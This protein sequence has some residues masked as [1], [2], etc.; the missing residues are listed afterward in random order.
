MT[1]QGGSAKAQRRA[2][3]KELARAKREQER[4][5]EQRARF[6]RTYI[7]LVFISG[8]L[9]LAFVWFTRSDEEPDEPKPTALPGELT[10]E[11]P[12]PANTEQLTE[13][14]GVLGLPPA[15][16]AKHEH[17]NL[18]IFVRGEAVTVP[19]DIGLDGDTHASLHTHD[20]AGTIHVESAAER[21]FTLGEF[22]DVWGV[23]L[24]A[25]CIGGYCEAGSETLQ[26]F[27]G[28]VEVS[29][30]ERDIVLDDRTVVVLA[31]GTPDQLPDP[32]PSTFDFD[33]VPE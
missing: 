17:A 27:V 11:A 2:H 3:K 31:F 28:G 23:R 16:D 10:T 4:R 1:S 6:I 7:T 30:A 29:G 20:E 8:L 22:F 5:R 21:D 19:V 14:L 33:S 26:T 13:R 12:W 25:T 9:V 32:I 15:G 18:R 24:T